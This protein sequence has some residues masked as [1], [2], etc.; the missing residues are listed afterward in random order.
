MIK[1]G[2]TIIEKGNAKVFIYKLECLDKLGEELRDFVGN[3]NLMIGMIIQL[4]LFRGNMLTGSL[5]KPS[6][7]QRMYSG[8]ITTVRR[9]GIFIR[10]RK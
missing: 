7:F 2:Y 9:C 8:D 5:R 3:P 4:M 1:K 6:K 10:M